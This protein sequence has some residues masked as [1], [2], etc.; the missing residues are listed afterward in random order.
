MKYLIASMVMALTLGVFAEDHYMYFMVDAD[1]IDWDGD[2]PAD[3]VAFARV[4]VMNNT[5]GENAGYLNIYNQSGEAS[6]A[7]FAD[8][9]STKTGLFAGSLDSFG[10]AYSFYIELMSDDATV[11]GRTTEVLSYADAM[12]YATTFGGTDPLPSSAFGQGGLTM[13]MAP[14]PEPNS[15]MLVL[16]GLAAL[17]LKRKAHQNRA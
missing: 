10:S 11:L 12:I 4:G 17:G 9:G 3:A 5:T 15:A 7:T 16:L 13:T 1:K 14:I 6:G 2:T 8:I